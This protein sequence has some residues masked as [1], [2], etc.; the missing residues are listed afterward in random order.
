MTVVGR[1]TVGAGAGAGAAARIGVLSLDRI[2][3]QEIA[4]TMLPWSLRMIQ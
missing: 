2:T 1:I 3:H 4:I